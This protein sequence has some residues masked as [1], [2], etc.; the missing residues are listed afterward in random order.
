MANC[1]STLSASLR[2]KPITT[3]HQNMK[4]SWAKTGGMLVFFRVT[5][6]AREVP[7]WKTAICVINVDRR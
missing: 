3:G 7:D 4:P 6:F 5:K 1:M 2:A